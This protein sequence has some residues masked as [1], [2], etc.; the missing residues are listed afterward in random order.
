MA[1]PFDPESIRHI[2]LPSGGTRIW[3]LQGNHR[4]GIVFPLESHGLHFVPFETSEIYR[5]VKHMQLLL[6][7]GDSHYDHSH[8][9]E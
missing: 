7:G 2:S 6:Q 5:M 4:D 8:A 9:V 3:D 1:T